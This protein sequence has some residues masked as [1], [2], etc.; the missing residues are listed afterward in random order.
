MS[1]NY[2]WVQQLLFPLS[3]FLSASLLFVIQPMVAKVLL[4]Y[5]G[6]TPAV[7]TVCMLFFQAL[8]L[9]AYAYAWFLSQLKNNTIWRFIHLTVC[10]LS[11]YFLPLHLSSPSAEGSPEITILKTLLLQLSLP[12]L[13]IGASAPLLQYAFSQT[14]NKTRKDPYYLYAASNAGSLLA[15]LSY[16]WLIERFSKVSEQFHGWNIFYLVYLCLVAGLLLVPNYQSMTQVTEAPPKLVWKQMAHWVFLSFVPC[17]LMLGVTFYIT[18][19]VAATPLFWVLP[20]ALYLL[21][22]V[23]TFAR[24]PWISY[25]WTAKHILYFL[26]FPVLGFIIGVQEISVE[27][28]ILA[29]LL[30]FFMLALFCHGQL[31]HVRPPVLQLTTFYFCLALGGVLAGLFNGLLAPKLFADAYEYP[32][33]MLLALLCIPI[34]VQKRGW[35][36]ATM[37]FLMLLIQYWLP[38]TGLF[39]WIKIHH[40]LE[41]LA[42]I[43]LLLWHKSKLDLFI[44]MLILFAFIFIPQFKSSTIL[45][46]QRNFYGIKQ[47]FSQ[48]GATVLMSQS[49]IHGFQ[50]RDEQSNAGTRAYYGAIFPV[51]QQMQAASSSLNTMIIGLGTGIMACQFRKQDKVT[52]VEID[53]QVINIAQNPHF[54][55]YLRDCLPQISLMQTDGR[56]AVAQAKDETYDL[57]VMDAFN[58][59]S[60]PAHLLTSEAFNLYQKKIKK[61]GV[62]LVNISNRHLD[63]LPVLTAAGRQ[64]DMVVLHKHQSGVGR[65]GQLSSDWVLLTQNEALAK[66]VMLHDNWRFVADTKSVLWTDDYTNIVPLLKFRW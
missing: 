26:V 58:S 55:T 14:N 54:F 17:S 15:L 3:L 9:F 50:F 45:S 28:L 63:V 19:D 30:G 27:Q 49:T 42:L 35:P 52:M 37:V 61:N 20:L 1:K 65:L 48:A 32:L 24:K 4:P 44:S 51:V 34:S 13:V 38:E 8:L 57:L 59:D 11:F 21:S 5:Y 7:W 25:D 2:A 36:I 39:R 12:L 18:K 53:E 23:V 31:A 60:I 47:V 43:I 22:F 10:L 16:P 29:H 56:L 6:G 66:Q 46:Q 62:I 40:I 41:I 64:I 33:V